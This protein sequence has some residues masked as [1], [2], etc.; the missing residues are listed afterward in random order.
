M[1]FKTSQEEFWAGS[2]GDE[3]IDRNMNEKLLAANTALFSKIISRTSNIQTIIEFGPNIGLNLISLN[4]LL[5]KAELYG[6]EINAKAVAILKKWGKA[7]IYH[8]SVLDYVVDFPRDLV[9]TKGLLIHLDPKMLPLVYSKIYE[10]SQK[11]ICIAEYYSPKS[12]EINYRGNTQKLFKRDFAGELLESFSDLTLVDYGFIYH[13]DPN[14][15]L[16]DISWFLLK[17]K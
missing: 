6:V 2:F 14:F 9:L 3:Y 16:D 5:P 11:Y 8:Q 4:Q 7:K 15:P 10:A 1:K 12:Q 13:R 17:K